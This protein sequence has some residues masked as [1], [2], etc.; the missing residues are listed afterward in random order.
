MLC[1]YTKHLWN[2]FVNYI[3][4]G[5]FMSWV[6]M[7]TTWPDLYV[8][9]Q[10]A[11][12]SS[13]LDVEHV[14]YE[15]TLKGINL[16]ITGWNVAVA[17]G[18]RGI[19][20]ISDIVRGVVAALLDKGARPFII[21]AM[22][23][24]GGAT[25]EGQKKVL[26][27]L[28]IVEQNGVKIVSNMETSVVGY[29]DGIPI[30]LSTDA[31]KADAVLPIARIKPHTAFHGRVESGLVKMLTIGLGKHAGAQSIHSSGFNLFP[32]ILI[33]AFKTILGKITVLCGIGVV[34]D[35]LGQIILLEYIQTRDIIQREQEL[36]NV[37]RAA[38]GKLPFTQIDL[39][40]VGTMGK[41]IS[42]AGLD[43]NVTGRYATGI[44]GTT[45][46]DRIV[47]LDITS[48][49]DGNANGVGFADVITKRLKDKINWDKTYRNA[50]TSR[51]VS[52]VRLPLYVDSDREALEVGIHVSREFDIQKKRI[53]A[54]K[55]TLE[56]ASF[57]VS[58]PLL[59]DLVQEC[60][61]EG[62]VTNPLEFDNNGN[63]INIAGMNLVSF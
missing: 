35:S 43:P 49:S 38:M 36:L 8:V 7:I 5:D 47:V 33:E 44:R 19:S 52:T 61:V 30:M 56:L 34:E 42:G 57:V 60:T 20:N 21:P 40:I 62:P 32:Q 14:A 51:Q 12:R 25:R 37:A 11:K 15:Q 22:G 24:H 2:L 16:N 63:L 18:S 4:K 13:P 48:E 9:N 58:E 3:Q 29:T 28:G 46:I 1:W 31:L 6:P 39:L 27:H 23:S 41:N 26:E 17:V 59:K 10:N 50:L 55:N 54:I 45:E 53:V